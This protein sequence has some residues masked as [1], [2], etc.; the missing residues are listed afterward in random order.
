MD[1]RELMQQGLDNLPFGIFIVDENNTM[2]FFNKFVGELFD[3]PTDCIGTDLYECHS[4]KSYPKID[5]LLTALKKRE[6]REKIVE[7]K[8]KNYKLSYSPIF[9]DKNIYRGFIELAQPV[10]IT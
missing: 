9:D 2:I 3:Y 10:D 4:R 5:E 8:G 7:E 6:P 1:Y